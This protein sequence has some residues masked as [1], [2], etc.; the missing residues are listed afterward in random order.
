MNKW[1]KYKIKYILYRIGLLDV[2]IKILH[3]GSRIGIFGMTYYV[4]IL[5]DFASYLFNNILTYLPIYLF[6]L[7]YLRY[8][9]KMRI[10]KNS[11]IHMGCRFNG[12]IIIG[13]NSVIG[14]SCI[15]MGDILIK[16]N[17]SV[18]AET[19]IFT[20][21]HYANSSTFECFYKKVVIDDYAWI[22][23]RAMILP[24]VHIGKGA[25]LGAASTAT[26]NIPNFSI[27]AGVP[28][29]KIGVRKEKLEYILNYF[30]YFQ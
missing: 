14:R 15:L 23:A 18:T 6:R 25:I 26:K 21:S 20:S 2:S 5:K 17:V 1:F 29:K 9:L 11:F 4:N 12:N 30:P 8:I 3:R 19:Y 27:Y 7:F 22:G 24:G 13:N 28:A 16:D 10:G